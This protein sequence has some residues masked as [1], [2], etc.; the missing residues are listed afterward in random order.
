MRIL[1]ILSLSLIKFFTNLNV[2]LIR[3]FYEEILSLE[4]LKVLGLSGKLITELPTDLDVL[5]GLESLDITLK[6]SAPLGRQ[7]GGLV[8]LKWLN[9]SGCYI[10]ELPPEIGKLKNLHTLYLAD[11]KL[12]Y[13]PKEIGNLENLRIVD[14]NFNKL[15]I[16]PKDVWKLGNLRILSIVENPLDSEE[17]KKVTQLL[18]AC[19][20]I[21]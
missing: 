15:K 8:N 19:E 13:I 4:N 10:T 3:K 1:C 11:N 12:E 20:I 18:P 17:I 21:K 6:K 9:L 16:I 14:L 7:I 2:N 5:R